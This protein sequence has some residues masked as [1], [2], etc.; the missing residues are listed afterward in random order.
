MH[1]PVAVIPQRPGTP[2]PWPS[3]GGKGSS[4]DSD[5]D[6]S[7]LDALD[8]LSAAPVTVSV[9]CFVDL[10]GSERLSQAANDDVDREKVRQKEASNIN[11][12]LLT[13]G[14]VIRALGDDTVSWHHTES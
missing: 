1:S 13:L 12:S 3:G 7:P 5:D 14:Q 8:A 11:R 4:S 6:A 9:M 10:A 2:Q